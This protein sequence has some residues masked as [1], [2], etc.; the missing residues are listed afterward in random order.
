MSK[1]SWY[2]GGRLVAQTIRMLSDFGVAMTNRHE[3]K[4]VERAKDKPSKNTASIA[5]CLQS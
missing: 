1:D 3:L 2:R 5:C 4:V